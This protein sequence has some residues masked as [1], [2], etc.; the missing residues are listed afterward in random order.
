MRPARRRRQTIKLRWDDLE[1]TVN[2][3]RELDSP[4]SPPAIQ[5]TNPDWQQILNVPL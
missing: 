2:F 4:V 5:T 3:K 1:T